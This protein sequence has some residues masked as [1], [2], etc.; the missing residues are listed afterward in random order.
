MADHETP[1]SLGAAVFSMASPQ[2]LI[3][4]ERIRLENHEYRVTAPMGRKSG[5]R[6]FINDQLVVEKKTKASLG[7]VSYTVIA[8]IQKPK[9][10]LGDPATREL[11]AALFSL[12][13][14]G[15]E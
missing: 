9:G 6:F 4:D 8:V 15:G 14:A 7:E 2:T 11:D 13:S 5:A 3:K 10:S 1:E 12:L